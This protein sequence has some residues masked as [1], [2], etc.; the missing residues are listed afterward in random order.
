MQDKSL[1]A[2]S[3]LKEE[4]AY[5]NELGNVYLES[6]VHGANTG[7]I[8]VL[9]APDGPHVGPMNLAIRVSHV[10]THIYACEYAK[11]A[12]VTLNANYM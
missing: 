6:K 4:R 2:W 9:S 5:R 12:N 3:K 10:N 11:D 1:Y 7:P 8:W